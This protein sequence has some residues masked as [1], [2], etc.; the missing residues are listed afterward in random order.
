[1]IDLGEWHLLAIF[2]VGLVGAIIFSEV[3]RLLVKRRRVGKG[4]DLDSLETAVLGMLA[5]MIGF[6]FAMALS[7]FDARR[8]ALMNEANAIGTTALRARLLPLPASEEALRLLHEYGEI[9]LSVI[10][11]APSGR[12]S[13]Q[14]GMLAPG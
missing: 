8:E 7:R 5:L 11:N 6:T 4:T 1:V 10:Q 13:L 9:R 2:I 14:R 12:Y 3:G